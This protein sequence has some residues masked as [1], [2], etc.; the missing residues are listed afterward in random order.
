MGN[1]LLL[2]GEHG[3]SVWYDN[4]NRALLVGGELRRL[5]AEDGVSGG[6]SNPSIFE[7][8]LGGSAVYDEHFRKLAGEGKDLDD[9]YDGLTVADIQQS[10]DVFR[11]IYDR[12]Q[13]ADGYAS[14]EVS[15]LLAYE[16]EG[17][18]EAARRLFATLDR[19]NA[20]IKIPGTPEALPAI[21]R[22]LAEGINVNVTLLFGVEN[23]EQ[24]A[25]T[26]IAALEK[27]LAANQPIDMVASVA[28]FFVSRV[29]TLVDSKLQKM[30]ASTTGP[31]ERERLKSLLG[32]A[33]IA[34]AKI[35]YAKFGEMFSTDRWRALAAKGARVQRCLWASTSTKNPEY[36]DVMYVEPF[37]GPDTINTMPQVTL[38]A[39]RDHG[40]V[41][42]TI[43]DGLDEARETID[44]LKRV[45][46]DFRA[47]T[48]ELQTQGV[49]LF[50][51]SFRN[52][53]D[54]LR[55]K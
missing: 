52:V 33:G 9:I 25:G 51:D 54:T 7:K 32:K 44:R 22:C 30:I 42:P 20:M 35:A 55:Q 43:E 40:Q 15:P 21:E 11:P 37:I 29:D 13:G 19:P 23:Y 34:N 3:Q 1:P 6:T 53:M 47:A 46:I 14:L 39:F 38:E 50:A 45:G 8:A 16:V 5:I 41:A 18:V 26:Y 27:R 49:Q 17:S 2:L 48:D 24:V 12:T 4:L 10:A 28:S 31:A 36:R